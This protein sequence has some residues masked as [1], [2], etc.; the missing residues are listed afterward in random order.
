MAYEDRIYDLLCTAISD[1]FDPLSIPVIFPGGTEEGGSKTPPGA[2]LWVELTMFGMPKQS[3][4]MGNS[5][6]TLSPWFFRLGICGK[7]GYSTQPLYALAGQTINGLFSK[8]FVLEGAT[9]TRIDQ[10]PELST[11]LEQ[12]DYIILPL[13]VRMIGTRSASP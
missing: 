1:H 6:P 5:G 13:T 9:N 10:E 4:G 3:Y 7:P 11:V 8:G 2:E 12:D